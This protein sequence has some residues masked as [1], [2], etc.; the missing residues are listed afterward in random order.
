[1]AVIYPWYL[2]NHDSEYYDRL[3][4]LQAEDDNRRFFQRIREVL[5][6]KIEESGLFYVLPINSIDGFSAYLSLKKYPN[7]IGMVSMT[8]QNEKYN[9]EFQCYIQEHKW[10]KVIISDLQFFELVKFDIN[11]EPERKSLFFNKNVKEKLR[12]FTEKEFY[13]LIETNMK[14][15]KC[16]LVPGKFRYVEDK[17]T[18]DWDAEDAKKYIQYPEYVIYSVKD[19][20]IMSN[21]IRPNFMQRKLMYMMS[22]KNGE[23]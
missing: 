9:I 1:M 20:L 2:F 14:I 23:A 6:K 5:P 12:T 10:S 17:Y 3:N 7:V 13:Y 8:P 21:T 11:P 19:G 22:Q 16:N 18:A 15:M 4:K